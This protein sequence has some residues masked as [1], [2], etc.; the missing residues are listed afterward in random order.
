MGTRQQAMDWLLELKDKGEQL[1]PLYNADKY[2]LKS[3]VMDLI[4][5]I[6][7]IEQ[8]D[9]LEVKNNDNR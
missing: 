9:M 5:T 3:L 1:K 8:H 2:D 7:T 4:A 6:K